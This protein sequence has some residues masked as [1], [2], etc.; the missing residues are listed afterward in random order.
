MTQKKR[1]KDNI[2]LEFFC[3]RLC[4]KNTRKTYVL[5]FGNGDM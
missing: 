5:E 3:H 2:K 1:K 4:T